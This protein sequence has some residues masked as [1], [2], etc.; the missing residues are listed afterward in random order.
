MRACPTNAWPFGG[1]RTARKAHT[2]DYVNHTPGSGRCGDEIGPG[3]VYYDPGENNPSVGRGFGNYRYCLLG[4]PGIPALVDVETLDYLD[5]ETLADLDGSLFERFLYTDCFSYGSF[6]FGNTREEAS[7]AYWRA[8]TQLAEGT[9]RM[10]RF[11]SPV[12]FAPF[13][14]EPEGNQAGVW[15]SKT[16]GLPTYLNCERERG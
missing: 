2:C 5:V 7:A 9:P 1:F 8:R 4:H 6:G 10:F 15:V 14:Q 3:D 13:N 11:Y 12:P 16:T